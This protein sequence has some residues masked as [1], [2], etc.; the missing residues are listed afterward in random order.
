MTCKHLRTDD[1]SL[2][3]ALFDRRDVCKLLINSKDRIPALILIWDSK[4]QKPAFK[5][6]RL[7][8]LK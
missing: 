1:I 2:L 4:E 7:C 5:S 3:S 8:P 6:H